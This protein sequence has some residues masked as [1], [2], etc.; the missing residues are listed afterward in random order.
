MGSLA[1]ANPI[2]TY[3]SARCSSPS[4]ELEHLPAIVILQLFEAN[5]PGTFGAD[6][7][8]CGGAVDGNVAGPVRAGNDF[9]A[10]K[11]FNIARPM[12][13]CIGRLGT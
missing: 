10:G 2:Y 11:D 3:R 8:V 1:M 12:S 6:I 9:K 5:L 13:G 7:S 4:F